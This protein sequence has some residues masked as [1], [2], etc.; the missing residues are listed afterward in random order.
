M[1]RRWWIVMVWLVIL[2]GGCSGTGFDKRTTLV[3]DSVSVGY[4]QEKYK[5]DPH[6]WWGISASATW[7]LK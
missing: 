3:P 4:M 2:L 5:A 6:A 1:S 7:E